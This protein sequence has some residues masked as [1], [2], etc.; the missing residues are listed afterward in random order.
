VINA[1]RRAFRFSSNSGESGFP[2]H[3]TP[4]PAFDYLPIRGGTYGRIKVTKVQYQSA[5]VRKPPAASSMAESGTNIQTHHEQ[6][7]TSP[8]KEV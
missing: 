3:A 1:L 4:H 6:Q 7:A 8:E 2:C 5:S